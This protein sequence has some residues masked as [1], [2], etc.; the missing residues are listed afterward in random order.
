MPSNF[1]PKRRLLSNVTNALRAQVTT[2]EDHGYENGQLV[3]LIVPLA[4]GMSLNYIQALIEVVSSNEFLTNLD[5][6]NQ[7]PFVTPTF[8]PGFT[9]AQVVPI[10]GVVDNIAGIS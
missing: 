5:T 10:T 9:P 1:V 6:R 8:P 7:N 4:Y 2:I 3:R